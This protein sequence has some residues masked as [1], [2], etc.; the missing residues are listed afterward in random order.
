M[1]NT[2]LDEGAH[3]MTISVPVP[4]EYLDQ[5]NGKPIEISVSANSDNEVPYSVT[6]DF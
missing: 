2:K 3:S 1:S 4:Q 6:I 5:L